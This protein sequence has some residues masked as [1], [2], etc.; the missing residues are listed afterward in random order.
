MKA[1]AFT[2]VRKPSGFT[3]VELVTTMVVL[4]IMAVAIIPRFVGRQAFDARGFYDQTKA[5]VEFARKAAVAERRNACVGIAAGTVTLT[6]G[7]TFGAAC[8]VPLVNPATG[9]AFSL[10]AP[11]GVALAT[12]AAAF[13]FDAVGGTAAAVT[14]TVDGTRII[15]VEAGTGYVH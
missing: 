7:V 9:A 2:D 3:L 4:A 10:T 11:A 14:I 15:T 12:S 8:T 6:R 5:A 1:R 13:T